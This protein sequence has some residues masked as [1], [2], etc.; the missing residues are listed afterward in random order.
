MLQQLREEIEVQDTDV[1]SAR[2][3]ED[4]MSRTSCPERAEMSH[5]NRISTES[6]RVCCIQVEDICDVGDGKPLFAAFNFEDWGNRDRYRQYHNI[7]NSTSVHYTHYTGMHYLP[8]TT[9][10]CS[11]TLHCIAFARMHVCIHTSYIHTCT[12]AQLR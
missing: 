5:V 6:I 11:F 9:F 7:E 2:T 4:D 10:A 12:H 1:F 8:Y 3:F